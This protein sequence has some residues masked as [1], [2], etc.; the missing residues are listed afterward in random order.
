MN[1]WSIVAPTLSLAVGL[2]PFSAEAAKLVEGSFLATQDCPAYAS[3][4][5]RTNPGDTRLVPGR[6]YPLFELNHAENPDHYRIRIEGADPI[7]RWVAAGCGEYPPRSSPASIIAKNATR[8]PVE[9]QCPKTPPTKDPCRTCGKPDLFVLSLNWA[10]VSCLEEP[11]RPDGIPECRALDAAS[12]HT[13]NFTLR[14]LA[15]KKNRCKK[16][17]GFCGPVEIAAEAYGDYPPIQ[18]GETTLKALAQ[19]MPGVSDATGRERDV[20]HR[21]GTC[22]GFPEE[23]YF[24]LSSDLVR[25]FNQSGLAAYVSGNSGQTVR[26]EDFLKQVDKTLG[27]GARNKVS[28]ECTSDGK[29]LRSVSV[30]LPPTLKPGGELKA[31]LKQAPRAGGKSNC[32]NQFQIGKSPAI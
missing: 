17:L 16:E 31:L 25:Q 26:R 28:L 13:G 5:E 1:L 6:I 12:Y 32:A 15:P 7:E 9:W 21:F 3:K 4:A 23:A 27:S 14:A 2:P 29:T 24:G 8:S 19:V 22:S 30:I 18:L 20:W 10:P 11:N